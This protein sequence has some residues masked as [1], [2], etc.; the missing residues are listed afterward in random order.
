MVEADEAAH[1]DLQALEGMSHMPHLVGEHAIVLRLSAQVKDPLQGFAFGRNNSRCDVYFANDP[2]RR[3]SNI[4]FRIYLNEYGVLMLEDTSMNGTIVDG[5]MLKARES[6][7]ARPGERKPPKQ[8]TLNPGSQVKV[9]M[10]E[11]ED[12]LNFIVQIPR[13]E[14]DYEEAYRKNRVRYMNRLRALRAEHD[15][16]DVG[17]T[18][19][20]GPG[21]HVSQ[22]GPPRE[23]QMG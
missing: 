8:R 10:A 2:C 21:G 6:K 3:L 4:H 7:G 19:T 14:G 22:D 9:L 12:D 13:R 18:I 1:P 23:A 20:P 15:D 11:R 5:T 16:G 17:K